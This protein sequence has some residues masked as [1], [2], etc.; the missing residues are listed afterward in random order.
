MNDVVSKSIKYVSGSTTVYTSAQ[1][2][3][4]QGKGSAKTLLI[5]L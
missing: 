1:K 2:S 3:I 4:E 5:F